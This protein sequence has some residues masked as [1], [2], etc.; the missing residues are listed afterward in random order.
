MNT[1]VVRTITYTNISYI[2]VTNW[3]GF[4][5]RGFKGQGHKNVPAG[6][7][8]S[9]VRRRLLVCGLDLL[10]INQMISDSVCSPN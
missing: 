7:I 8:R 2:R 5:G 9:T 4:Q 3:L 6:T 1:E 10:H